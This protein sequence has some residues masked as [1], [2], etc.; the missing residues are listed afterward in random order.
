M[1]LDSLTKFTFV[2]E[3]QGGNMVVPHTWVDL[4]A[5]TSV[6]ALKKTGVFK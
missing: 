3:R 5:C 6:W 4:S 2:L 1:R